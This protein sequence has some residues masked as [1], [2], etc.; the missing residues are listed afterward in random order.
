MK[1]DIQANRPRDRTARDANLQKWHKRMEGNRVLQT[2]AITQEIAT[3][4]AQRRVHQ[5]QILCGTAGVGKTRTVTEALRRH[6]RSYRIIKSGTKLGLAQSLEAA[7]R[8]RQIALMD[9]NESWHSPDML[10]VLMAATAPPKEGPRIYTHV[11]NRKTTTYCFDHLTIVIIT[12]TDL[13][14]LSN[15]PGRSRGYVKALT[16]RVPPVVLY[17]G[18]EEVYNYTCYLAINEDMLLKERFSISEVND[19]LDFFGR[20]RWRLEDVSPRK[21]LHIAQRRRDFPQLWREMLMATLTG[22]VYG[23]GADDDIPQVV[24]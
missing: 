20:N 4:I 5:S 8:H 14:D 13:S 23:D 2:L 9:D 21:L 18:H 15:F 1:D 12:N 3:A 11:V 10:Q 16:S 6:R 17:P 22:N 19:A 7:A 24:L